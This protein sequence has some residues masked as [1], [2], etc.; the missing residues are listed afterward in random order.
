MENNCNHNC[1]CCET[2]I[3]FNKNDSRV[4]I[5][6]I[7]EPMGIEYWCKD[8]E[9]YVKPNFNCG[10]HMDKSLIIVTDAGVTKFNQK[11]KGTARTR[12]NQH[13]VNNQ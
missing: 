2:C 8:H 5:P 13:N 7:G 1:E 12:T 9:R 6:T 11:E 10:D 4:C 3:S